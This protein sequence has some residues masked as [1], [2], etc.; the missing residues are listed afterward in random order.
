[1]GGQN[2]GLVGS[3]LA[4][5]W[6]LRP[7]SLN[8]SGTGPGRQN[9]K[10]L[11]GLLNTFLPNLR[12]ERKRTLLCGD[13]VLV[14]SKV[15]ATVDNPTGAPEIPL[16]PGVPAQSLAGKSFETMAIDLHLIKNGRM[17]QAWHIED[18]ATAVSQ[19]VNRTPPQDL[20]FGQ[21]YIPQV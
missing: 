19:M 10:T 21:D 13:K 12:F 17:R 5:D 15:T 4:E 16:F 2:D 18:W 3:T 9:A 6:Q 14:V 20:G 8:P 1:M 11:F 7:N